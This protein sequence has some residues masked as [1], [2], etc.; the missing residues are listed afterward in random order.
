ML[1]WAG[2]PGSKWYANL[3]AAQDWLKTNNAI[4][5]IQTIDAASVVLISTVDVFPVPVDVNETNSINLNELKP[6]GRHRLLIENSFREFFPN[7]HIVRLPGLFGPGLKKNLIFDLLTRRRLESISPDSYYQWYPLTRLWRDITKVRDENIELINLAT[8]PIQTKTLLESFFP[9]LKIA[10]PNLDVVRYDVKTQ[11]A[12][13]L[14]KNSDYILSSDEVL[15]EF[16]EWLKSP[17]I[18]PHG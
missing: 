15:K 12:R 7:C 3:N 8:E 6:Y 2:S 18:K 17:R 11:H 14:G 5:T 4:K 13:L 9:E 10:H 1:V 16:R